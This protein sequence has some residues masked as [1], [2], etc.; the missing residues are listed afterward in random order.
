MTV[1]TVERAPARRSGARSTRGAPPQLDRP[2]ACAQAAVTAYEA[3]IAAGEKTPVNRLVYLAYLRHLRDQRRSNLAWDAAAAELAIDFYSDVLR[4][5][6]SSDDQAPAVDDESDGPADGRPFVLS[7]HHCFIVG[8]MF[9][10]KRS[11]DGALRFTV[12]YCEISKGDGKTPLLGGMLVRGTCAEGVKGAQVFIAAAKKEQA[13]LGMRDADAMRAASPELRDRLVPSGTFPNV[14]QLTHAESRSFCRAISSE[15]SQSG[16]RVYRAG[17]DELHEHRTPLV[18]D[19]MIAGLKGRRNAFV[20]GI[21]NSGFDRTSVCWREHEY[22]VKVLE[23][24]LEDDSRFAFI[25]GLD[26]CAKCRAEGKEFPTEDCAACDDWRDEKVWPKAAP[27]LGVTV[28]RDYY[29]Q[30][31]RAAE[32]MPTVRNTVKR[33][34]FCI[35]TEGAEKWLPIEEWI[36]CKRPELCALERLRGRRC[37]AGLDLAGTSD[38]AAL[39]LH[40]PPLDD[41]AAALVPFFF[42]PK[43]TLSERQAKDRVPYALWVEKKL[44]EATEGDV[45]DYRAIRAKLRWLREECGFDIVEVPFDPDDATQLS[46]ELIEDGFKPVPFYQTKRNFTPA[47]REA[48]ALIAKRAIAH[49]GH[50]VLDWMFGNVIMER[51]REDQV[52]PVKGHDREKNDGMVAWLEALGRA[53]LHVPTSSADSAMGYMV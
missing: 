41:E 48:E 1:A 4:L 22:S 49:P 28:T 2:T 6:D 19:M 38:L 13:M 9:G 3:A 40:F 47:V 34:Q 23:G 32:G 36:A 50:E 52:K 45:T 35:W 20:F 27:N 30:Q 33:L 11:S 7:P 10:W 31:V 25:T 5:P 51:N 37:F 26:P 46:T 42:M 53:I 15:N 8:S 12:G 39:V 17:V 16:P 18:W 43:D 24:S 29:R 14:W 44:I 21:T